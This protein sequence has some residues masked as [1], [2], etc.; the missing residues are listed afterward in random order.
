VYV[1]DAYTGNKQ[2]YPVRTFLN[3]WKT[4][5]RMAILGHNGLQQS[6]LQPGN[7]NSE[8]SSAQTENR[9]YLPNIHNQRFNAEERDRERIGFR[10][11]RR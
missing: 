3:S 6:E 9:V 4:L 5:G 1:L 11:Y 2:T 8:Q 10:G 7:E